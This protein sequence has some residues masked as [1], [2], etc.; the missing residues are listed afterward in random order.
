MKLNDQAAIDLLI[1]QFFS[2]FDNRDGKVPDFDLLHELLFDEV[3]IYKLNSDEAD[4]FVSSEVMDK[5]SFIQP[6]E[7]LFIDGDIE[8]FH[9]W[10]TQAE[11]NITGL[12][13]TRVSSYAKQGRI[14]GKVL[15]GHG[16]KHFQ[17]LKI[18]DQWRIASVIWQDD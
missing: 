4:V 14:S 3:T 13:A 5:S 16:K 15:S 10:E 6:R 18:C 9:E 7:K 12:L 11:T 2:V 8:S 17:L 1:H